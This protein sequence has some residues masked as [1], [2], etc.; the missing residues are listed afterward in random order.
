MYS[1]KKPNFFLLGAGRCGTTSLYHM[2]RQ[3][4]EI[5]MPREKE[6]SFFCSYFQVVKEPISYFN[7][8]VPSNKET[9]IGEASH[10]YLSNPETPPVLYSLFPEAKFILIFR[11]PVNR[12]YSLYNWMRRNKYEPLET[13]EE[14]IEAEPERMK[15]RNFFR[16]CPQYYYNYLYITSSYYHLQ[17][18]RY[19]Q[20]YSRERFFALSLYEFSRY[21]IDWIQHI[22]RF[23]NVSSTFIPVCKYLSAAK[24]PSLTSIT[25]KHLDKYFRDAIHNTN[26]IAGRDLQLTKL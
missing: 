19:L 26:S 13:F 24:Y 11:N 14:A 8:F 21:P 3:H 16:Q 9:A 12:A 22:Y 5:H 15:S 2:L 10:V 17:W 25:R 20:Y 18:R 23:L 6:P 1:I 7:L 4:P